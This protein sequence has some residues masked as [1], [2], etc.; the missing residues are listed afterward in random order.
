MFQR[1]PSFGLPIDV[2]F[3]RGD[4]IRFRRADGGS[5]QVTIDLTRDGWSEAQEKDHRPLPVRLKM[6]ALAGWRWSGLD[7]QSGA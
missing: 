6:Q 3:R 7:W 4:A 5:S 2:L 1:E